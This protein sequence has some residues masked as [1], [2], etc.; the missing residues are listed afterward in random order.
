MPHL[1]GVTH[2]WI[3]VRGLSMHVAEAGEGEPVILLHGLPQNWWEWHG[4]MPRLAEHYRVLAVDQRGFGWS[5]APGAGYDMPTLVEDIVLLMDALGIAKARFLAHDWGAI[6][7]QM[8][9]MERP[10]LVE[11]L[12]VS[13]CPDLHIRPNVRLLLLFPK[14][15]HIFALAAPGIG[16]R[17][18]H[19]GKF[20]RHLLTAFEPVGGVAEQDIGHYRSAMAHP[21]R[22]AAGAALCRTTLLPAFMGLIFGAYAKRDFTVPTLALI[23]AMEPSATLQEMGHWPGRGGNVTTEIVP[24]EGHFIADHSPGLVAERVLAFFAP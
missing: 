9:A 21:A 11:A 2:R 1:A 8:L 18:Q 10:D 24:G 20:A 6:I 22:A 12:V 14:L 17:I 4:V 13:G 19:S 7:G 5:D 3:D 23:G 15:W 16:P